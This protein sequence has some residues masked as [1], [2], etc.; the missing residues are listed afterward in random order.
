MANKILSRDA[1]TRAPWLLDMLYTPAELARE[2][3]IS[4]RSIHD[5]LIPHGLP[6]QKDDKGRVWLHGPAVAAWVKELQAKERRPKMAPDEGYCFHCRRPV[7]MIRPKTLTRGRIDVLQAT[8]P[9]CG[10]TV[11]R[12]KKKAA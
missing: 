8:C 4:R 6:C 9:E 10:H 5:T 3:G 1:R 12:G 11:N 7:K 2:L